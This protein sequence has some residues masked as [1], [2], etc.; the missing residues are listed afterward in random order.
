MSDDQDVRLVKYGR[1]RKVR[2]NFN[3]E[4]ADVWYNVRSKWMVVLRHGQEGILH[5]YPDRRTAMHYM[6]HES[7]IGLQDIY[8]D[9]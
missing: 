3:N 5:V 9:Q 8:V 1:L 7:P 4:C 6:H 2:T